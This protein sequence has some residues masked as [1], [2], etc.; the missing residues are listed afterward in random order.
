MIGFLRL[1]VHVK[2]AAE[3]LSSIAESLRT[4]ARVAEDE[5]IEKHAPRKAR[6][7]QVATFDRE[8][9]DKEW[10]EQQEARGIRVPWQ[11]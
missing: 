1:V 10:R 3:S 2:R 11:R 7:T 5:W 6:D 9:A 4:I 8:K